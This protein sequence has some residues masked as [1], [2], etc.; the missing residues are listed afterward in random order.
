MEPNE[1]HCYCMLAMRHLL[2]KG[3][4]VIVPFLEA[5]ASDVP[6]VVARTSDAK[7]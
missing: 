2:N 1:P 3:V 6:A 5:V 7:L 4:N